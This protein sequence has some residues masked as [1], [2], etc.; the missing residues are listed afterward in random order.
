MPSSC[1]KFWISPEPSHKKR[2]EE[3]GY[4]PPTASPN[5]FCPELPS[6][7][8][9]AGFSEYRIPLHECKME[10]IFESDVLPLN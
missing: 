8:S 1:S 9:Q 10:I 5:V 4:T 3:K 6:D 2:H 7:L